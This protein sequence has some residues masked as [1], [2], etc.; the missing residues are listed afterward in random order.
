[1]RSKS[2]DT[3]SGP[4]PR[5]RSGALALQIVLLVGACAGAAGA[6]PVVTIGET[7]IGGG[8]VSHAVAIDFQDGLLRSGFVEIS[9]T[10]NFDGQ[11]TLA[12][13]SWPDLQIADPGQITPRIYSL[14]GGTG[15]QSNVDV[16]PV[17]TLVLAEGESFTYSGTISR[18][19]RNFTVVPEA[20]A[21]A[22]TIAVLLTVAALRRRLR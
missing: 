15:G 2:S 18:N 13:N 16:V 17:A 8:L 7:P 3:R 12:V 5:A 1:M 21:G 22:S 9:F 10:G 6:A 11:S 4:Q 19:G 20:S 14:R